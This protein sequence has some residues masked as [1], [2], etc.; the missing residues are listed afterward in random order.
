M[1]A[2]LAVVTSD[3]VSAVVEPA[4]IVVPSVRHNPLLVSNWTSN[5]LNALFLSKYVI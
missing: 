4:G 2:T 1:V 5:H 3:V